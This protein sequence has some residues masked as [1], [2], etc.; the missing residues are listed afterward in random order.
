MSSEFLSQDEVDALL[1]GVAG[2]SDAPAPAEERPFGPRPYN[3]ANQERIVR[4][5]MPALEGVNDRF[6]RLVRGSLFNFMRRSP[7][8]SVGPLRVVK[9]SEFVRNLAVPTNLNV[10]S[11]KP[12]RGGG[13]VVLEPRLVFAAIDSL[14]GGDGRF[15]TRIEGR[16]FTATETRIIM[17]L[18]EVML[19]EY[20]RAWAPVHE[21]A[22][23]H[24]RSEVHT[25][26]ANVATP[27]EIVLATT[28]S[29]DL[30]AGGGDA[31]VCLPYA[32]VEPI[33]DKLFNAIG[34]EQGESGDA[35]W[36]ATLR[37]QIQEARVEISARLTE[38]PL[39]VRDLLAMRAGDVIAFELPRRV[40]A[41]VDGVALFECRYGTVNKAYAIKVDRVVAASMQPGARDVRK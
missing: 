8:V 2:E 18:L 23:E 9:Y 21:M 3:L 10:V 38:I 20:R 32:S 14:F 25:Q 17:R 7:E 12:L 16:E 27:N 29:F 5:R 39:T 1:K 4:G 26:F 13:L 15:R 37:R 35:R 36:E 24:V 11:M 6:A 28:F 30:G 34:G 31:H 41:E 22:F 19:V 40:T 33:R